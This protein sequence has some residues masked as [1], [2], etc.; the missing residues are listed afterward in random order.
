VGPRLTR[1]PAQADRHPKPQLSLPKLLIVKR[2][3]DRLVA[4]QAEKEAA[5]VAEAEKQQVT[6]IPDQQE[7]AQEEPAARKKSKK[8]KKRKRKQKDAQPSSDDD[9]PAAPR[10]EK[11]AKKSHGNEDEDAT[12]K[13]QED[14]DEDATGA[15]S[16]KGKRRKPR[17]NN[18]PFRRV[19][20]DASEV[21]EE[22]R[23]NSYEGTFGGAGWGAK[24]S[25]DLIVTRG[26]GFRHAK[27]KKKRG[28]VSSRF[29]GWWSWWCGL[30]FLC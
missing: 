16:Q 1:F 19:V 7:E 2:R 14:E 5:A 8:S 13:S 17:Q 4:E 12:A 25:A 9:E 30:S 23:D 26:K 24:A 3:F 20:G 15:S 29:C 27:T 22:L 18:A 10:E 11:K 6:E 28:S 21:R